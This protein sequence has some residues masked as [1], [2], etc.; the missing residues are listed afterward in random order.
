MI[1]L[2]CFRCLKKSFVSFLQG[3][4][5]KGRNKNGQIGLTVVICFQSLVNIDLENAKQQQIEFGEKCVWPKTTNFE[6]GSKLQHLEATLVL[7]SV[8]QIWIRLTWLNMVTVICF[9]ARANFWYCPNC[10][11]NDPCFKSGQKWLNNNLL[12]LLV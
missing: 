12:A 6:L 4:K 8:S 1:T 11:K 2:R 9:K 10:L 5:K 3:K 7:K